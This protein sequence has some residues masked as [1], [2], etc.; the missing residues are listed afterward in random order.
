[1]VVDTDAEKPVAARA[2]TM[3][4]VAA[5]T[6]I[7]TLFETGPVRGA[8][9]AFVAPCGDEGADDVTDEFGEDVRSVESMSLSLSG[10]EGECSKRLE[11]VGCSVDV[12]TSFCSSCGGDGESQ[13]L[14]GG[15][16]SCS[17][18]KNRSPRMLPRPVVRVLKSVFKSSTQ[19]LRPN[20]I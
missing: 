4:F 7:G 15:E 17:E 16:D 9:A 10:G 14:F 6:I 5:S 18:S 3:R 8:R 13:G 11:I 1:M 20:S 2:R 12:E 19:C